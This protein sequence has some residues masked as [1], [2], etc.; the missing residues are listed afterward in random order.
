MKKHLT[1]AA[2]KSQ[3]NWTQGT[4]RDPCTEM[5]PSCGAAAASIVSLS[6]V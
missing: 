3:A 1:A 4:F 6:G 5:L 2:T